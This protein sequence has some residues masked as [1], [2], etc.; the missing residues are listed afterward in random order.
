MLNLA[1]IGKTFHTDDVETRALSSVELAIDKGEF[2]SINGPSGSGKSTLLSILGLL[3]VPSHGEYKIDGTDTAKLDPIAR[4]AMRNKAIGFIFQAFNLIG[5]LSVE[6]NVE[7]PLVYRGL[8]P[9]ERKAKVAAALDS[10]RMS[11]RARHLPGQLSGGQQQRV[12]V[13]RAVAGDPLIL[14]ADEPTGNL[15]SKNGDAVM[16]LLEELHAAGATICMVT[17]NPDYA[18]KAS[19]IVHLFDGRVVEDR[20]S[21]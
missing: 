17:H 8:A 18:K 12:A 21:A 16:E 9:A 1:K 4:A 19:R 5:D 11:H 15:D 3:D 14:L 10:V 2:V 20:K 13:A 6:E 7:L